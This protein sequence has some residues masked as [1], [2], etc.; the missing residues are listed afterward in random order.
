MDEKLTHILGGRLSRDHLASFIIDNPD[1][2]DEIVNVAVSNKRP[3]C[4]RAA[5]MINL[6]ISKNDKRI[7]KHILKIIKSI[8]DKE[9][10]HQRELLKIIDRLNIKEDHEGYL[11]DACVSIWKSV[12][13]SSS[14]RITAFRIISDIIIKYPELKNEIRP[15]TQAHYT[16]TLSPGIKNTFNR[17]ILKA[18]F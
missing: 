12:H 13:K 15:L 5:W 18:T 10:G 11:F 2:F 6:T 7:H 16:D 17:L 9:D 3:Y 14:V 4:W 1:K 8:D